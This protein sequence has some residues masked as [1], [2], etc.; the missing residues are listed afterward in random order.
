MALENSWAPFT[1][2]AHITILQSNISVSFLTEVRRMYSP[3]DMHKNVH[4]NT[5]Q[6]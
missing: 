6:K 4:N 1:N 3:K 5:I 2:M